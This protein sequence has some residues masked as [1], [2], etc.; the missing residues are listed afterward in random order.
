MLECVRKWLYSTPH[1]QICWK[2]G[3]DCNHRFIK[4]EVIK[5][6]SPKNH[7]KTTKT[8][9]ISPNW[10]PGQNYGRGTNYP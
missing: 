7:K 8:D 3:I 10:P 4:S 1:R 2:N 6:K 9:G 5:Q